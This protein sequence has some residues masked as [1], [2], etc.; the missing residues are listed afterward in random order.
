M[1]AKLASHQQTLDLLRQYGTTIQNTEL[2]SHVTQFQGSVEQH[3]QH[4][5]DIRQKLG[6]TTGGTGG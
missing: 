4:A 2:R 6:G 1:D 3:L 5:K